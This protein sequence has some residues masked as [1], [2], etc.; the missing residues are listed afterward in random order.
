VWLTLGS[1]VADPLPLVDDVG[2]ER[3]TVPSIVTVTVSPSGSLDSVKLHDRSPSQSIDADPTRFF[4][5]GWSSALAPAPVAA[6]RPT[7]K[8]RGT[9]AKA[10]ATRPAFLERLRLLVLPRICDLPTPWVPR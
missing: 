3:T 10:T 7:T 9:T 4:V 2:P 6:T 5:S 8:R 1:T